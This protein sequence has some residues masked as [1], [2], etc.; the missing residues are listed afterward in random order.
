MGK[1]IRVNDVTIPLRAA[2]GKW[3]FE[4]LQYTFHLSKQ[5]EIEM[6][7]WCASSLP[8][9]DQ[10][11][12][13]FMEKFYE[14]M[15][16]MPWEW[17]G[18]GEAPPLPDPTV[19]RHAFLNAHGFDDEKIR[20]LT[21]K[22][23]VTVI[24]LFLFSMGTIMFFYW[25]AMLLIG[26]SAFEWPICTIVLVALGFIMGFERISKYVLTMSEE[27][28]GM[29]DFWSVIIFLCFSLGFA[30]VTSVAQCSFDK[31]GEY[32]IC[33]GLGSIGA[34]ISIT[35][36]LVMLIPCVAWTIYNAHELYGT[37]DAMA[38]KNIYNP[39]R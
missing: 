7:C 33:D 10:E 4:I 2:D 31:A 16:R 11:R 25:S 30:K 20:L 12:E 36:S 29:F 37:I 14:A 22:K 6:L 27:T 8:P 32:F 34:L 1:Y 26:W 13:R 17:T 5:D 24:G 9:T 18:D 35:V 38:S 23:L 21:P 15:C 3:D 19:F 28:Q 39:K